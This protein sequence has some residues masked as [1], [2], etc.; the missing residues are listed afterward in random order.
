MS[1]QNK[2]QNMSVMTD[3]GQFSRASYQPPPDQAQDAAP[4]PHIASPIWPRQL[5][6]TA[7]MQ[8]MPS[9]RTASA[10]QVPLSDT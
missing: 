8:A 6:P 5:V 10:V 4:P 1:F 9:G 2:G 7:V 3:P